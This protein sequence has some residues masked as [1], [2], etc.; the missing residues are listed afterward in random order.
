[1][2]E[3]NL[4]GSTS[5]YLFLVTEPDSVNHFFKT[6]TFVHY[7]LVLSQKQC[8]THFNDIAQFKTLFLMRYMDFTMQK[9]AV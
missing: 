2:Q 7:A 8:R 9:M 3:D 5:T 4:T 1:M 6:K